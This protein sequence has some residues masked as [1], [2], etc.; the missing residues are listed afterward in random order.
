MLDSYPKTAS[1]SQE[2]RALITSVTEV[3]RQIAGA[4]NDTETLFLL[5]VLN[6]D[7][8]N[9]TRA[10]RFA[11]LISA[12]MATKQGESEAEWLQRLLKRNAGKE[13]FSTILWPILIE[14]RRCEDWPWAQAA[15]AVDEED[16]YV[17]TVV[18]MTGSKTGAPSRDALT[19]DRS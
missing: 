10:L 9:S 13:S 18:Q 11:V 3:P 7:S 17:G 16:G 5:D 15:T 2:I 4:R 8:G 1:E 12:H 6:G 19:H 14:L